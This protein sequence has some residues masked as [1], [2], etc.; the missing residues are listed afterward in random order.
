M[1]L[2]IIR[3]GET[4]WNAKGL[5]QGKQDIELNQNGIEAAVNFGKQVSGLCFDRIYCS[6]LKRAVKTAELIRG[7]LSGVINSTVDS[8]PIVREERLRELSFGDCEGTDFRCWKDPECKYHW[9]FDDPS[10]YEP[11]ANGESLL[12]LCERTKN[13]IQ[14]EIEPNVDSFSRIMIVAHGALNAGIMTYLENRDLSHFWGKGL[15]GNCQ[16]SVYQYKN[17]Q[18]GQR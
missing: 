6:P 5:L 2:Y 14:T 3:H 7:E 17:R 1:E 11:P 16:A 10:K 15:Q 9:F 4:V 12:D 8:V 18:W 13:F